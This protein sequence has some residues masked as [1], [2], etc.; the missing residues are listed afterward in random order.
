MIN[1]LFHV[2]TVVEDLD[3]SARLYAKLVGSDHYYRLYDSANDFD[4]AQVP[5]GEHHAIEVMAPRGQE[6]KEGTAEF[7]DWRKVLREKGPGFT[8]CLARVDDVQKTVQELRDMGVKVESVQLEDGNPPLYW[9]TPEV[10]G[11]LTIELATDDMFYGG[12]K[13]FE[14]VDI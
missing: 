6:K 13:Y 14:R 11:G 8:H 2:A 1:G 10:T 12:W 3:K 5:V 7:H 4:V 9:L